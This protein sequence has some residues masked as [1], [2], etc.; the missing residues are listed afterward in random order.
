MDL[1]IGKFSATCSMQMKIIDLLLIALHK[2]NDYTL[3][4]QFLT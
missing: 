1:Y 2:G 4:K 3:W